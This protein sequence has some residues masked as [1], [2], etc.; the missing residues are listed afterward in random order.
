[1]VVDGHLKGHFTCARAAARH[2]RQAHKA[3]AGAPR[4]LINST[5]EGGLFPSP[6]HA[7]YLAAK[8]GIMGLTWALACELATY[9]VTVN[10]IA[11][12]ARTGMT[13]AMA[14]FE[15]PGEGF[16][17]MDPANVA[18]A[19]VWLAGDAAGGV[20][21]QAFIVIGG[22]IHLVRGFR[23]VASLHRDGRW[24]SAELAGAAGELFGGRSSGV[25]PFTGAG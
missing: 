24:S 20:S 11:A 9:G 1:V 13:E 22:D 15:P 12:R 21:G 6:G 3:G 7:N 10:A 16:D 17:R 19:V 25:P 2:W 4:R 14:G 5:A 18:P 8:A 23:I